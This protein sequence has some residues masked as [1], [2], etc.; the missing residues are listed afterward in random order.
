MKCQVLEHSC[1]YGCWCISTFPLGNAILTVYI[2]PIISA[3]KLPIV[4]QE[5]MS[6]RHIRKKGIS[7]MMPIVSFIAVNYLN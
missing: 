3:M 2:V 5:I 7:P 6:M 4:K 1:L